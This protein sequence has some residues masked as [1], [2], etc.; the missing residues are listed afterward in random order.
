MV[1]ETAQPINAKPWGCLLVDA[2]DSQPVLEG[3]QSLRFEVRPD[4]CSANSG[5]NDCQNDRSRHEINEAGVGATEGKVLTWEENIF[6][7]TQPRFRPQG[8]N[9]M[10]LTQINFVDST[11]YGTLAYVEVA[12]NGSLMIRTH[13]GLTFQIAKQ[14]VVYPN[15]ADKWI[16]FKFVVKST[17]KPDGYV[18]VFVDD[19]LMVHETRQTLPSSTAVNWLKIGIYN[20]Y[21]S[22]AVEPYETQVVY[23]GKLKKTVA[24]F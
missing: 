21:K 9:I 6:I 10:F 17:A 11:N 16:K 13:V 15:P 12:Q 18:Q 24:S 20:A 22:A 3:G 14:Y 4:D 19:Q 23:Y 2:A 1:F 8:G 5:F 7:P